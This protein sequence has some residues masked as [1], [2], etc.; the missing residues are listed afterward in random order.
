[1]DVTQFIVANYIHAKSEGIRRHNFG[2]GEKNLVETRRKMVKNGE[3][4]S[5]IE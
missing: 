1:M 4:G 5:E 3:T 2:H